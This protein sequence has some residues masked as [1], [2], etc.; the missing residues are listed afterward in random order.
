MRKINHYIK[1]LVFRVVS[2]FHMSKL[3]QYFV[4]VMRVFLLKLNV[5]IVH[6]TTSRESLES[7][8]RKTRPVVT[9]FSL[10]RVGGDG[11][12]GYLIP[13]DLKGIEYCFSPGVSVIAGFENELAKR[14]IKCF[15]ADFSVEK[16]PFDNPLFFFKKKFIGLADNEK[17]I[18]LDTWVRESVPGG[19]D[20]LLQMDIEGAE[21]PVLLDVDL[22][23]LKRFRI[24]VVEFHGM[25]S[26]YFR[27]GF[28]LIDAVFSKLLIGFDVAHIH[29]NNCSRA[30]PKN[31]SFA[32]PSAIEVTFLRK[33]RV[34]EKQPALIFPHQL[35]QPNMKNYP[36]YPLPQCW[37]K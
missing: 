19:G 17:F 34:S 28:D 1:C 15:M 13:D 10:I 33:D 2:R 25:D 7:F 20:L 36:D 8:F 14:G 37:Y 4:F 29:P 31:G 3:G 26:L 12:G 11:D 22:E 18:R 27:Q 6:A 5:S 30:I 23:L 32:V 21:Y 35:D 9:N 16:A 24:I